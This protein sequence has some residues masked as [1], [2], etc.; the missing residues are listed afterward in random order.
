MSNYTA[1][2]NYDLRGV[3]LSTWTP[4]IG[5]ILAAIPVYLVVVR[6]LRFQRENR[7]IRDYRRET[8][9]QGDGKT[10]E[11]NSEANEDG[12]DGLDDGRMGLDL[13][14]MS[15]TQASKIQLEIASLEFPYSFGHSLELGFIQVRLP[16]YHSRD[17]PKADVLYRHLHSLI[18]QRL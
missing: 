10:K 1:I 4:S 3:S 2:R 8:S 13:G 17:R 16:C 12:N 14:H 15:F 7:I 9:A 11:W 5:N 18:R 6:L